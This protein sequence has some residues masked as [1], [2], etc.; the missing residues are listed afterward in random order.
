MTFSTFTIDPPLLNGL[1]LSDRG[2]I[3]GNPTDAVDGTGYAYVI[4]VCNFLSCSDPVTIT[5]NY[6]GKRES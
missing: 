3:Y 2:E 1:H 6:R 4:T 5:L